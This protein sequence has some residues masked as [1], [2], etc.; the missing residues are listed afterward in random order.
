MYYDGTSHHTNLNRIYADNVDNIAGDSC[1]SI[2]R[3]WVEFDEHGHTVPATDEWQTDKVSFASCFLQ[4]SVFYEQS[5]MGNTPLSTSANYI[6][7]LTPL[8]AVSRVDNYDGRLSVSNGIRTQTTILYYD[9]LGR[10]TAQI[11]LHHSPQGQDIVSFT[12]YN[13]LYNV[14]Q[15]WLPIVQD[16]DGQYIASS[17]FTDMAQSAYHDNRPFIETIFEPSSI[18][19]TTG[20]KK[21]GNSYSSHPTAQI[22]ALNSDEDNV[23]IYEV[24]SGGLLGGTQGELLRKTNTVYA[25]YTLYKNIVA[26]EDG[27]GL[28]T[29]TDKQGKK[30]ME[31]RNGNETYY[32]YDKKNQLRYV[33]PP[34][35]VNALSAGTYDIEQ[36][37]TI[38]NLVYCYQYVER[39]NT[40][41][42]RLP[43]CEPHYMVY[44]KAGQLVL[45]QDGNQRLH[46]L[47]TMYAYDSIGRNLYTLEI[48]TNKTHQQLI[49]LYAD[50]WQVEH[51]SSKSQ[52]NNLATTGYASTIMGNSHVRMLT[53]NYYDDYAFLNRLSTPDRQALRYEHNPAFGIQHDNAVGLLTGT[54]IYNL[55]DN[56]YTAT[57]YYYDYRGRVVQQR[58][59]RPNGGYCHTYTRYNF[60]GTI[61]AQL[62]EQGTATDMTREQYTHTYDHNGR[63]LTTSYQ[64]NDNASILLSEYSYDSIGHLS[65]C[66]RHNGSDSVLYTYDLRNQPTAIQSSVFSEQLYYADDLAQGVTP[67]YNGN[68]SATTIQQADTVLPFAYTYD[69]QNQLTATNLL[70]TNISQIIEDFSYDERGNVVTLR[71]YNDLRMIDDLYY[72]YQANSNQVSSITDSAEPSDL[73]E[74][75]EYHDNGVG[76][77]DML[78]DAN[79]NLIYDADRGIA[80]IRYNRLNLPD[81]IQFV[82]GNQIVNLY[83]ANG[84]KYKTIYYTVLTTAIV[85]DYAVAHY[86]FDSDT[87]HYR[88][89]EYSGNIETTYTQQDTIQRIFNAEG[90]TQ[91]STCNQSYNDSIGQSISHQYYY[92][93]DHLENICSVKDMTADSVVQRTFYYPSG[94]PMAISEGQSAQ[95]YKYNGKEY[96]EMYGL[97]EYAYGF[98][99]Y[100]ASTIRFTTF[101]PLSEKYYNLSPYSYCANNFVNHIDISGLWISDGIRDEWSSL[102]EQIRNK[103]KELK[104]ELRNEKDK[105]KRNELRKR[106]EELKKARRTMN[107]LE[108]STQHY[109][110]FY[111]SDAEVIKLTYIETDGI[112]TMVINYGSV[113]N[114][115]HELTHAGQF[116]DGEIAYKIGKKKD[117]GNF[118]A[119]DIIDELDAYR[120][121]FGYDPFSVVS[122]KSSVM[123]NSINDLSSEW[124]INITTSNG[125][126]PYNPQI[127]NHIGIEKVSIHTTISDLQKA[128]PYIHDMNSLNIQTLKDLDDVFYKK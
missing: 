64:L 16:G 8:D 117:E 112:G 114:F 92:Y 107:R 126:T 108:L 83:D 48:P 95:P 57:A 12:Q 116:D 32:V 13:G 39:G 90:Y 85:P 49:A 30:I 2:H 22:Y 27:V 58:S 102:E 94:V 18:S 33:L 31:R 11:G 86:G 124:L 96:V 75:K 40:I 44:D 10:S 4:T 65:Q 79:G 76:E 56:T 20:T 120:A 118:Y 103:E 53:I 122:L 127:Y 23:Q 38:K 54:R 42:K 62:T 61:A 125:D 115:I 29:F 78:Y 80:A 7:S 93:K 74:V 109:S 104:E 1:L 19:R 100:Y 50:Q 60:D 25:P 3:Q 55:S 5:L 113:A 70:T 43:G 21:A 84:Y 105:D 87:V 6:V 46:N 15:R 26:D 51:Y 17:V 14:S 99:N 111:K 77:T 73:Y 81:T 24:I 98:R 119:L 68:L 88:I 35:P 52:P 63:L 67:R 69:S 28:T 101:D 66:I 128:Y 82:N 123:I 34:M 47:W 71:R 91:L 41:Y 37:T 9:G 59:T 89:V 121:Q 72:T 97:D 110:V 106:I 36:N 45:R